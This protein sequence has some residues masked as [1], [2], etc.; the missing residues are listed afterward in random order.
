MVPAAVD[1]FSDNP[2]WQVF[3]A[4]GGVTLFVGVSLSL[5]SRT[6]RAKLSVRQAFGAF[7]TFL[8]WCRFAFLSE[9]RPPLDARAEV[10]LDCSCVDCP[11]AF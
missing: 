6:G 5:T 4:A 8:G 2:D 1:I 7:S 11:Q 3:A 9:T 10:L